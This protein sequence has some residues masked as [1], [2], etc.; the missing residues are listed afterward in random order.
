MKGNDLMKAMNGIDEKYLSES[1]KAVTG[2]RRIKFSALKIAVS[3]AAAAAI[4]VPV[5]AYAY[6][7]FIHRENVEQYVANTELIEQQ[8]PEAVKNIVMEN[9]DYRI[10][11]DTAL[12]DGNIVMMVLTHEAKT[13]K[14]VEINS[15]VGGCPGACI[16][17]ADGSEGP[18]EQNG[19]EG[20]PMVSTLGGYATFDSEESFSFEKTVSLFSCK[21]IDLDKEVKVE[22]YSGERGWSGSLEYF[23][24]RNKPG[25]EDNVNELDGLEFTT[26]F[27]P[28]V[29]CVPLYSADGR[30]ISMS[31][32]DI[33]SD[34][35]EL[36]RSLY[37]DENSD[38]MDKF[39]FITNDGERKPAEN[40]NQWYLSTGSDSSFAIFGEFIDPD[41]YKGVEIDGVEYTR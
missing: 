39:Y 6:N 12:S 37:E 2:E 16:T 27:A 38:P 25:H 17:Y 1:E 34:D 35:P 9:D 22:F 14:G 33:Y 29:K 21:D 26:S 18:F 41:E 5:G 10:T 31:S 3:I 11:V 40:K 32:F 7:T 23:Y 8:S 30:E 20:V 36:I 13:E 4:A 15:H 19:A 28:N 24:N